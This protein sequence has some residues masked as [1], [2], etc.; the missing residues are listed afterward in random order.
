MSGTAKSRRHVS[1]VLQGVIVLV[2]VLM[3]TQLW[4]FTRITVP[5]LYLSLLAC[6]GIWL[7]IGLFL[8]FERSHSIRTG[9]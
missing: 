5:A 4:L 6:A 8:R 2:A 1:S 9:D 7:L 3:I